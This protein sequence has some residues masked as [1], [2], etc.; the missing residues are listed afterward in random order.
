MNGKTH[1]AAGMITGIGIVCL[2]EK[3]GLDI[4]AT[5]NLL[6]VA[7]CSLGS[8]LPDADIEGSM[9][10][11][12]I[13]LWLVC[14]H[15]TWTHSLFFIAIVGLLGLVLKA[16][17]TLNIGLCIGISTHLVLDGVTPMGIPYLLYPFK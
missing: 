8:L 7:G 17:Y 11:R 1:L 9:L 5:D 12:F 10:G 15:R 16:P 3:I 6:F 4:S 13:P 2:R 14:E